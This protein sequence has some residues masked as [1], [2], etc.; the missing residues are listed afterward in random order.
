MLKMHEAHAS[1]T[2][3]RGARGAGRRRRRPRG[4]RSDEPPTYGVVEYSLGP[5]GGVYRLLALVE[6]AAEAERR[7]AEAGP[8]LG[9]LARGTYRL[10]FA[11]PVKGRP[12]P[13]E[14]RRY[15]LLRH[16]RDGKQMY[17]VRRAA[18][19]ASPPASGEAGWPVA[20]AAPQN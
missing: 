9:G 13:Q 16:E 1:K 17:E 12:R 19:G 10:A 20:L 5:G 8:P 14:G 3:A 2:A 18:A 6:G 11:A 7:A 15:W 4:R